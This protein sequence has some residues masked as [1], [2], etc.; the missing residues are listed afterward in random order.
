MNEFLASLQ[1]LDNQV[2]P[3]IEP[4]LEILR[5]VHEEPG[6]AGVLKAGYD[7][8]GQSRASLSPS[9][10]PIRASLSPARPQ[11]NRTQ[12]EKELASTLATLSNQLDTMAPSVLGNSTVSNQRPAPPPQPYKRSLNFT[13]G[14]KPAS[15]TTAP[16]RRATPEFR[17]TLRAPRQSNAL[18]RASERADVL[19]K[20]HSEI[21]PS[22]L[23]EREKEKEDTSA[24]FGGISSIQGG[25]SEHVVGTLAVRR[26]W[27]ETD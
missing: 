8:T 18:S 17:S 2:V 27:F 5:A 13:T 26:F 11:P 7:F 14:Q 24:L 3:E 10:A 16:E 19:K 21:R 12:S 1:G 4:F 6:V 9:R 20:S 23:G 22:G 15:E 25:P